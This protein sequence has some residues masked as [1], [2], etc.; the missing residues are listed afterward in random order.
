MS[1]SDRLLRLLH[2]LR[3]LPAPVTAARLA[4]ETG[5]SVRQVYRDVGALRAAGGRIDGEAGYGY[6]LAEDPAL[7]EKDKDFPVERAD[8]EWDAEKSPWQVVARIT[9]PAQETYSDARQLFVD[10][11]LS[12]SPWHAL[13]AHRPLGGIMRSRLKAYE[14]ARKYRAQRNARTVAEPKTIAEVPA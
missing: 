14:E 5:V 7:E 11:Q 4:A 6:A 2:A 10:E 13:E 3:S 12:F 9:M 8:K 1:R